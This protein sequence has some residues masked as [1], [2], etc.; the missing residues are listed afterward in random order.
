MFNVGSWKF[1]SPTSALIP[2]PFFVIRHSGFVIFPR[3]GNFPL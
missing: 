3:K 1:N 2:P